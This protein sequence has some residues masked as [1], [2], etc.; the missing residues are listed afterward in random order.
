[1][2]KRIRVYD[3]IWAVFFLAF[4]I[5]YFTIPPVGTGGKAA[6]WLVTLAFIG[7]YLCAFL[8]LRG[9]NRKKLFYGIPM[10]LV[11]YMGL[12]ATVLCGIL[13]MVVPGFPVW[14]GVSFCVGVFAFTA[15]A[16]A[17]AKAE[18]DFAGQVDETTR[19]QTFF[20]KNLTAEAKSLVEKA[21]S[22]EIRAACKEVYEAARYSDPMSDVS[23]AGTE[24]EIAEKFALFSRTV[25]KENTAEA[26]TLAKETAA[27]LHSRNQK[28]RM[29]K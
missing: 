18:A 14:A 15:A 29:L 24:S 11:S 28:C 25:E 20:I 12:A 16:S 3:F 10:I 26:K 4:Q 21:G 27:I 6:Y 8:A 9:T 17:G 7:Q 5:I 1:M 13:L 23:L 22:E 19:A 2:N